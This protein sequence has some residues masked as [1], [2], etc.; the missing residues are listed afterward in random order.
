MA[1]QI[2]QIDFA[3]GGGPP[4]FFVQMRFAIGDTPGGRILLYDSKSQNETT[5]VPAATISVNPG[6]A[7]ADFTAGGFRYLTFQSNFNML[8]GN[9]NAFGVVFQDDSNTTQSQLWFGSD[10]T[11]DNVTVTAGTPPVPGA[12]SGSLGDILAEGNANGTLEGGQFIQNTGGA[13]VIAPDGT[14][15]IGGTDPFA[16]CFLAGT[17]LATPEGEVAVEELEPGDR[18]LRA[19]GGVTTVRWVGRSTILVLLGAP[20]ARHPVLITAGA[21][22]GGLPRRDLRVT[23]DHAL[24]LDGVAVHAA[25]LVNGRSIRRMTPAELGYAYTVYHVETTAHDVILAEGAPAESF[26]DN[27]PRSAFDNHAEYL[28]LHGGETSRIAEF[29]HPRAMSPRQLPAALRARLAG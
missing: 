9:K 2:S 27:L 25:A 29:A 14:V 28:A 22:G 7:V 4:Q 17:R 15:T 6:A 19:D 5:L 8:V 10:T 13:F 11:P 20:A 3:P 23:G 26:I 12:P 21:L 24:I 18:L 1:G 16:P